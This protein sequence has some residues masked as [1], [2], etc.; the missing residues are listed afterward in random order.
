MIE[1]NLTQA[2]NEEEG[3]V[4][5]SKHLE[6]SKSSEET[7]A[8]EESSERETEEEE[9]TEPESTETEAGVTAK[10]MLRGY[11]QTRQELSAIREELNEMRR[12]KSPDYVDDERPLTKKD[13]TEWEVE[14]VKKQEEIDKKNLQR[15]DDDLDELRVQ[16]II[17]S[18]ADEKALINYALA[19]KKAGRI[20]DL[21]TAGHDWFE[22]QE[23]KKSGAKV[24]AEAKT[25]V[26]QE[27]GS[28]IGTSSK[29]TT[30]KEEG[31]NYE[32][33]HKTDLYGLISE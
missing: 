11:T 5:V 18:E 2:P 4:D 1:E 26:K 13:L 12:A 24:V 20:K 10:Q 9:N 28:K 14:K 17:K 16:G 23:A 22:L 7:K 8:P 31:F 25:K 15:V 27:A 6:E 32:E 21:I 33:I 3:D 30:D 19:Q 29:T